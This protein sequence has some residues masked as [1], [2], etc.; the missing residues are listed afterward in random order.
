MGDDLALAQ[1]RGRL[2][3]RAHL[4]QFVRNIENRRSLGRQ[5]AQR[6]EKLVGFLRGQH[7]GRFIE[8]QQLRVLQQAAHDLDPLTLA[9]GKRMHHAIRVERQ[10]VGGRHLDH[11]AAQCLGIPAARQSQSHVFQ[12]RQRFEQRQMLEHHADTEPPRH[13]R[14]FH[15]H[16]FALPNQLALV[17]AQQAV[18]HFDQGAL[19]GA[20]FPQQGVDLAGADREG[21]R[22]VRDAARKRLGQSPCFQQGNFHSAFGAAVVAK[23]VHS[24][25]RRRPSRRRKGTVTR[26]RKVTLRHSPP[27]IAN[28]RPITPSETDSSPKSPIGGFDESVRSDRSDWNSTSSHFF[29]GD[30]RSIQQP[31]RT[32]LP[33]R[34]LL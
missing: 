22:I 31:W 17:G 33:N 7:A 9:D 3:Q 25:V 15:A 30:Y 23:F 16:P 29:L 24:P 21:N 34:F 20:V 14:R 12:H 11:P 18:H 26:N 6:Q 28:R 27:S 13:R 4:V 10:A 32:F 8:N 5:F 19:A 2:T 1:H